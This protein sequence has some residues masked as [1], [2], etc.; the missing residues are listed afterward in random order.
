MRTA[1]RPGARRYGRVM[2]GAIGG[3]ACAV[4]AMAGV[5]ALGACSNENSPQANAGHPGTGTATPAA[6]GVQ[7]IVVDTGPSLR[8]YPSTIVVH[9][10][11]VQLVLVNQRVGGSGGPPHDLKVYGIPGATTP[12]VQ[13]GHRVSI[14]FTAGSPG[15]YHFVCLL[16]VQQG[17]TGTLVVRPAG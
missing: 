6:G 7:R 2:R 13:S 10:G 17:Q 4:L 15:R 14:E 5:L 3:R 1:L 11:K 12:Y 16:H 9:P 8:F